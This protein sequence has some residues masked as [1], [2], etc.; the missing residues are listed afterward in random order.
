MLFWS[1]AL[2]DSNGC[3]VH[4]ELLFTV[5]PRPSKDDVT[6][7][8][9]CR[10]GE[11]EILAVR[12]V[13]IVSVWTIAFVARGHLKRGP[14]VNAEAHLTASAVVVADASQVEILH[15][16]GGPGR[17]WSTFREF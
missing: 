7:G 12:A 9:V 1:A 6:G 10:D 11:V 13:S 5:D 8:N 15:A 3:A 14:L 4:V 2:R 16:A 17:N